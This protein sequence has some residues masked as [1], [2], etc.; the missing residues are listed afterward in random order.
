MDELRRLLEKAPLAGAD[1]EAADELVGM[2]DADLDKVVSHGS[3]PTRSSRTC[4][5]T[6]ERGPAAHR[7]VNI[8]AMVEEALNL[9]YLGARTEKPGCDVTIAKSLDDNADAAELYA[10]KSL[11][12]C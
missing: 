7:S 5:C 8:D 6:R 10:Q 3:T 11:G 2:I 9:A 4:S 1:R 12:C